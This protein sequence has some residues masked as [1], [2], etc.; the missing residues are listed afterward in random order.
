MLGE[1]L[2]ASAHK[3]NKNKA[4]LL[5]QGLGH[6]CVNCVSIFLISALNAVINKRLLAVQ[7]FSNHMS[8]FIPFT[9]NKVIL[10]MNIDSSKMNGG[11]NEADLK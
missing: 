5:F 4:R 11:S 7:W 10:D 9:N 3:K 6:S 8:L 1:V 2:A